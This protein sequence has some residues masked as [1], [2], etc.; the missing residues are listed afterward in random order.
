MVISLPPQVLCENRWGGKEFTW[1]GK[2]IK[3]KVTAPGKKQS[4]ARPWEGPTSSV[5][6]FPNRNFFVSDS[7][8]I[9]DLDDK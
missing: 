3:K 6:P 8:K 2:K 7:V 4:S 9:I 1:D 5:N